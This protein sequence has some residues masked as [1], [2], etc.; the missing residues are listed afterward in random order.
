MDLNIRDLE[1][2]DKYIRGELNQDE[3]IEESTAEYTKNK[4]VRKICSLPFSF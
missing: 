3:I 1:K 2:A 4:I